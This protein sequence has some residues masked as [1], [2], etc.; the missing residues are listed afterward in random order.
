MSTLLA[1]RSQPGHAPPGDELRL[2]EVRGDLG[3]STLEQLVSG[4]WEDVGVRAL[5]ACPVCGD[6]MRAA[7]AGGASATCR[8]CGS[9]IS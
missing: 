1:H 7:R 9:Q 5:A 6:E 4:V 8:G 3:G 2:H